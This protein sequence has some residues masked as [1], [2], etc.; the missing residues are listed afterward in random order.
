M[1]T[2]EQRSLQARMAAHAL[3]SKSDAREITAPARRKFLDRFEAEVDPNSELE[4]AERE[5]RAKHA[6]S[7]YMLGLSL[8]SVAARRT[9]AARKA[10]DG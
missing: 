5:R 1:Q 10:A 4:P 3:H 2:P 9:K 8:K 6:R 7:A